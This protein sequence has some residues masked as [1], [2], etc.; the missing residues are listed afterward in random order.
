MSLLMFFMASYDID[1][2]RRFVISDAFIKMYNL[3]D[4]E[5][6]LLEKGDVAHMRFGF[7]ILC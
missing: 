4:E 6:A 3:S 5:Y 7:S 1:R 2:F